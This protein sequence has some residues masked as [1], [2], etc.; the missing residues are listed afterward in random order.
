MNK[1]I[2]GIIGTLLSIFILIYFENFTYKLIN[3]IGIDLNNYSDLIQLIINIVIKIIICFIIYLIYKKD[4]KKRYTGNNIIRRTLFFIIYLIILILVMYVF[5]YVI[6][7]VGDI[8]DVVIIK[9]EFYNI[10]TKT[11][12]INLVIKIITDYLLIPFLYCTII[13][14]GTDKLCKHKETFI[15]FSGLIASIIYA[16]SIH[17]TLIYVIINSL[18]MFILFSIL[19]FIYKRENSIWMVILLYGFYLISNNLII[20]YLGW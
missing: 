7:F 11:L 14:L 17:G 4:F 9:Q 18:Y 13:L 5:K 19:A 8:F 10:F 3:M 12:N 15:I 2:T 1:K 16:F 6:D 20:N